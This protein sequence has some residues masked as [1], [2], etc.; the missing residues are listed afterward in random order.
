[1]RYSYL[2][3]RR[4]TFTRRVEDMFRYSATFHHHFTLGKI[5]GLGRSTWT[6]SCRFAQG[7]SALAVTLARG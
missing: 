6:R 5:G 2:L 7:V 1:M 3:E 4:E